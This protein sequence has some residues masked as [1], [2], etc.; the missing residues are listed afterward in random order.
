MP[1]ICPK[2]GLPKD[3]CVCSVLDRETES[4]IKVYTKKAKFNRIVTIVEGISADEMEETEK[5]LKHALACGG[6][7]KD[8]TIELQGDHKE[9][10]RKALIGMGY[11]E[12]VIDVI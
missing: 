10:T 11:K 8:G 12:D 6:T 7:S 9:N 5:G 1:E 3:I 4:K 2:C